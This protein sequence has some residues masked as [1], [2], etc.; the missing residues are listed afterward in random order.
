MPKPINP[1]QLGSVP[2]IQIYKLVFCIIRSYTP[3][4]T[5]MISGLN[6]HQFRVRTLKLEGKA[7]AFKY[8]HLES[9]KKAL[10]DIVSKKSDTRL[11]VYLKTA[12]WKTS[13]RLAVMNSIANESTFDNQHSAILNRYNWLYSAM[14]HQ[15]ERVFRKIEKQTMDT[16]LEPLTIAVYATETLTLNDGAKVILSPKKL[17]TF[18][19]FHSEKEEIDPVATDKV[20]GHPTTA[21]AYRVMQMDLGEET[22]LKLNEKLKIVSTLQQHPPRA[23]AVSHYLDIHNRMKKS[24]RTML[25]MLIEN[26]VDAYNNPLANTEPLCSLKL[27]MDKWPSEVQF[28]MLQSHT[29][30]VLEQIM[31][32]D[33][34]VKLFFRDFRRGVYAS[35][36]PDTKSKFGSPTTKSSNRKFVKTKQA[37]AVKCH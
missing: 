35:L 15:R 23:N 7:F 37:Y 33:G 32:V 20:G 16:L 8:S 25:P 36:H 28:E 30:E 14:K 12:I 17:N 22:R 27:A 10:Q 31:D 21:Y 2:D 24:I 18:R 9:R 11:R 13:R 19:L 26:V 29:P 5:K 34:E 3:N 4:P 1:K 6:L